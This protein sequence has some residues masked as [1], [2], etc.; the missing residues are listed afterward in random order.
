MALWL[1]KKGKSYL[2]LFRIIKAPITPGIHPQSVRRNT[3]VI[4]PHPRSITASGGKI[5]ANNTC[6]QDI[7]QLIYG[8]EIGYPIFRVQR[9]K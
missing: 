8:Q 3:M 6:K 4:D 7:I 9:Y 5:I 1:F 2:F